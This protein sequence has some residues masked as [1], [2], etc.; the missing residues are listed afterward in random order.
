MTL[1]AKLLA[2]AALVTAAVGA[3]TGAGATMKA[4]PPAV[5]AI[6]PPAV[7]PVAPVS[8]VGK[9]AKAER[10][11][12][13]MRIRGAVACVGADDSDRPGIT[14]EDTEPDKSHGVVEYYLNGYLGTKYMIHHLAGSGE[15][16]GTRALGRVVTFRVARYEG[17]HRVKTSRWKTVR[18]L[19]KYPVPRHTQITP[20]GARAQSKACTTVAGAALTCFNERSTKIFACDTSADKR[21]VRAE[22][23]VGGDPTAR[24][25]IHQLAGPGTCGKAQHGKLSISKYRAAVFGERYR[26]STGDYRYN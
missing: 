3:E 17:G 22:Y 8:A 21:E 5:I 11:P 2:A 14:I 15:L 19:T 26:Y 18:N 25:E 20:A 4:A 1:G 7:A 16:K 10:E 24:Y 6:P 12:E 13:C 23:F 9:T